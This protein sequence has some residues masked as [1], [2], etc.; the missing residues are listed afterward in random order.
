MNN[1]TPVSPHRLSHLGHLSDDVRSRVLSLAQLR[2]RGV[3][4]G[5][6]TAQCRPGG[7]WQQPL[8]GVFLLHAG[9][10]TAEERLQAVLLYAGRP[11]AESSRGVPAQPGRLSPSATSA[12]SASSTSTSPTSVSPYGAVMITG[13]AALAL[14]GFA[15]APPLLSLDHVD[16][17]VPRTR[18]LRSTGYA[19][20][21]RAHSLPRP[22]RI[23]GMP[24]APVGRALADAVAESSDADAVVTL[25][26]E[27]VR[28][29]HCEPALV[30]RELSQSGLLARQH[31]VDAVD[32]LLAE[33]RTLAEGRLYELVRVYGLQEPLWNVDLRLPGGPRLGGVDA[34]WPDQAVAVELDTRAPR[35][36]G[37]DAERTDDE[38]EQW[39]AA[40][41]KREH[42]ER[43]GITVVHL[44]PRKL[45]EALDQ[46][47]T[48]VRTALMA[49]NDR[50]P[51]A[52]VVILPR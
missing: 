7:P 8:P 34:Y 5:R 11:S 19:R 12:S 46:Q 25:L 1:N 40:V 13:L 38:D 15:S 16:V 29:G 18:R 17:L 39:S 31:V 41:R 52:Q 2:E 14:Y 28:A 47:A 10:P 6:A 48:V 51:A 33:G 35:P 45:R 23:D 9:P 24:V 43:L 50:D 21:I 32:S 37:R 36:G 22:E 30:V 44:T 49:A 3:P 26:T 20:L 4:G 42:L 27:A